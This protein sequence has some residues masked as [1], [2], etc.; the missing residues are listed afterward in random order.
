MSKNR[1]LKKS[2]EFAIT[3]IKEALKSEPNFRIHLILAISALLLASLLGFSSI[4]WLI[5]TFTIFF[6]LIL[7]LI[8]TVLEKI[9]DLVSPETKPAARV[10]K[11]VSAATVLLSA[12]LAVIVGLVLFLP[13]IF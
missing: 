8:N 11:D 2:F 13:K 12:I 6:V 3:G 4:E 1:S 10:A 9:V 5:L 7:E